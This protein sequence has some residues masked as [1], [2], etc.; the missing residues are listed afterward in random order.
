[1]IPPWTI[2]VIQIGWIWAMC[3]FIFFGLEWNSASHILMAVFSLF[4]VVGLYFRWRLA[5]W[6]SAIGFAA[7]TGGNVARILAVEAMP[8]MLTISLIIGLGLLLVHQ[9]ASSLRWFGF[10]RVRQIRLFFWSLS[11]LFC[12]LTEF[13]LFRK[14]P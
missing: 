13:W 2:I 3:G 11:A 6:I 12:I 10:E 5:F 9:T 8:P 1:M 4:L 14:L 7:A